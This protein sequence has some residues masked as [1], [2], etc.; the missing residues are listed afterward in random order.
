MSRLNGFRD[1]QPIWHVNI[2][3]KSIILVKYGLGVI[4]LFASM[5]FSGS[6]NIFGARVVIIRK[7]NWIPIK[8]EK[9]ISIADEVIGAEI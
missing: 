5:K 8:A 7:I 6:I 1:L 3:I 2:V 9:E 4:N